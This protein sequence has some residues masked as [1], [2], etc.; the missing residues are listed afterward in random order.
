MLAPLTSAIGD[1]D[2]E[3]NA[4]HAFTELSKHVVR[5]ARPPLARG[6]EQIVGLRRPPQGLHQAT[7][8]LQP[9]VEQVAQDRMDGDQ[10]DAPGLRPLHHLLLGVVRRC[11]GDLAERF[12][13]AP[14]VPHAKRRDLAESC[15]GREKHRAPEN[16]T[17]LWDALVGDEL[18]DLASL[19]D[20]A[21]APIRVGVALLGDEAF[22]HLPRAASEQPIDHSVVEDSPGQEKD[23][24]LRSGGQTAL[25]LEV[26]DM[27]DGMLGCDLVDA[28]S[29][30]SR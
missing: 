28:K 5:R 3:A 2:R 6:H 9:V 17:V 1:L 10:P 16:P 15:A 13:V 30:E 24:S 8:G 4:L 21:L 27:I 23:V 26:T 20:R 18:K 19:V 29:A 25:Q 11:D 14:V 22:F 7:V 12:E